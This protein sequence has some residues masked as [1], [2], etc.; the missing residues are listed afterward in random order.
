MIAVHTAMTVREHVD[1]FNAGD[2]DTLI[3]GFTD[4]AVWITGTSVVSGRDDLRTFFAA[5][6]AG[7]HPTL[8]V[9]DVVAE[10]DRAACQLTETITVD[11]EVRS[12]PIAVFFTLAD[13]KISSA[14]VYREGSA[15]V[16]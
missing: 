13:R 15:E 6:I 14:K 3:D 10:A 4:D 7:L 9:L 5:A 1:A 16:A 8:A 11:G 2:V 12:F